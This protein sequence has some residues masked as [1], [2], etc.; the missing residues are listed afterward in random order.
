M[1]KSFYLGL[2]C[3][4]ICLFSA[5]TKSHQT[6]P[7]STLNYFLEKLRAVEFDRAAE[8]ALGEVRTLMNDLQTEWKMSNE[9]EKERL[10]I[11]FQFPVE[12]LKCDTIE[13]VV[14]CTL[15]SPIEKNNMTFSLQ[16]QEKYWYIDSWDIQVYE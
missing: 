9:Q 11:S 1:N 7:E 4:A 13:N 6:T 16:K 10:K 5:C 15:V 8:C 2:L 12:N 3:L 14:L